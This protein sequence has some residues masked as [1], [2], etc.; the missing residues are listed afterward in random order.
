LKNRRK[1]VK[2]GLLWYKQKQNVCY[3]IHLTFMQSI[4]VNKVATVGWVKT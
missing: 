3:G 2:K 4:F 1:S